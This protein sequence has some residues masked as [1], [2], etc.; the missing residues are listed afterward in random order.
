MDLSR[1]T[2]PAVV[3]ILALAGLAAW[4]FYLDHSA[5]PIVLGALGI[6]GTTAVHSLRA[7]TG[8]STDDA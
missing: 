5:I 1:L 8:K 7:P 2:W 4:G 6:V 3:V